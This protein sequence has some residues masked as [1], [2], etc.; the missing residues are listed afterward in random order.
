M[1]RENTG[2]KGC[3]FISRASGLW[4]RKKTLPLEREA[5]EG[6]PWGMAWFQ[7]SPRGRSNRLKGRGS[8]EVPGHGG[9]VSEGKEV[10]ICEGHRVGAPISSE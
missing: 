6:C 8:R 9:R 1:P 7:E 3:H 4:R 10:G 5:E 2:L